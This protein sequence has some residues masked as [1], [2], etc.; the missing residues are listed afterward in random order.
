MRWKF[1]NCYPLSFPA[2]TF[3]HSAIFITFSYKSLA[4]FRFE[5]LQ[6]SRQRKPEMALDFAFDRFEGVD[7]LVQ[8]STS[9]KTSRKVTNCIWRDII[10]VLT[11]RKVLSHLF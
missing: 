5:L 1:D 11:P 3:F 4:H 8:G 10:Y 7:S 9:C 6:S 2:R